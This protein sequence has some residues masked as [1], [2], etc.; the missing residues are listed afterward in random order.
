MDPDIVKIK[1]QVNKFNKDTFGTRQFKINFYQK[2][3]IY[4]QGSDLL[5][6][7]DNR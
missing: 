5:S 3:T 4:L 2:G 7:T 6:M 1:F